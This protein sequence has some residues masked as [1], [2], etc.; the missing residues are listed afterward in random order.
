MRRRLLLGL[1][2]ALPCALLFSACS[3]TA[4]AN[5]GLALTFPQGLLDQATSVTL[6]VFDASL[7]TCQASGEVTTIPPAAQ[8]YSLV[9]TD[10]PSGDAWC[11]KITLDKDGSN[12]MFAVVAAKAGTTIAEGCTTKVIDQ[13]PLS[14]DIQVQRYAPPACCNDGIIEP[15]EQCDTGLS[16]SCVAGGPLAAC[17][18]IVDDSVCFCDCTSK[19][20]QLDDA[21]PA[22]PKNAPAGSKSGLTLSFGPG[23]TENPEVLRAVYESTDASATSGIDL[24]ASF[25]AADLYPIQDPVPLS[26]QLEFP[27]LCSAVEATTGLPRDQ[28][29]PALATAA[30]DTVVVVYQSNQN[31]LGDDWDIFLNPQIPEGC[32]DQKPCTTASQC[33]TE[34]DK[35]TCAVSVQLNTPSG[36][37]TDPHVASGP[38]GTVLVTWTRSD[39]V[40]GRIWRSSDGTVFPA[41]SEIQIAPGGTAARVGGSLSGFLVAYQGPGPGDTDGVFTRSV[42]AFGKVG[43]DMPVNTVTTGLQDQPDIAVLGD[44]SAIVV[45][46]SAGDV[47][48]QRFDT[49]GK[50]A[51]DDQSAPLN[52]TGAGTAVDQQ[53]PVVAGANGYFVVAWET[54]DPKTSLGNISARFVGA[55]AGFGYNSVSGQND[56][57]V[58][59]DPLSPGDRHL[60][61]V[62]MSTYTAIGWE[63]HAMA[64]AGIWVRRFPL[65]AM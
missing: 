55:T 29:Y 65:P 40:Y 8:M 48:F 36:G 41:T 51:P 6:S 5:L 43:T 44:G 12:K 28:R 18:G 60:P 30:E 46:H 34:C 33:Q 50:P 16:G 3:S 57:F 27:V 1:V 26:Q 54:V 24:H 15:G 61:A 4:P 56:E 52:T 38:A 22:A 39:G 47:L 53:H 63:D 21:G 20:I 11:T 62:A 32:T 58:A 9:T 25:R 17:G 2:P 59:T 45:W 23:G 49:S 31:A 7:A 14:V 19:E 35:G 42:D 37:A 13:D 10:C 64:H